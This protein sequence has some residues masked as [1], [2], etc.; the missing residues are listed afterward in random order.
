MITE[1]ELERMKVCCSL[2]PEPGDQIVM[3]CIVE[4]ERLR[5]GLKDISNPISYLKR[6]AEADGCI[7]NGGMA[8]SISRDPEFLMKIARDTVGE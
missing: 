8:I 4:I 5:Q 3:Q 1:V 6:E 2:L 7:L